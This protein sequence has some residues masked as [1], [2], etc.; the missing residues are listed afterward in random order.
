L[1]LGLV[2]ATTLT[3]NSLGHL[4]KTKFHFLCF[5]GLSTFLSRT[6]DGLLGLLPLGAV[7]EVV[8][9]G[10]GSDIP[11]RGVPKAPPVRRPFKT[12]ENKQERNTYLPMSERV[13][14][15]AAATEETMIPLPAADLDCEL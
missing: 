11:E 4:H 5:L 9:T 1:V 7:N 8:E 2:V 15:L 14:P 13:Q 6:S 3:I 12:P 10:L